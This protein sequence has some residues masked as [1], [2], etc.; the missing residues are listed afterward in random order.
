MT[1]PGRRI[2]QGLGGTPPP[3]HVGETSAGSN[4]KE[5]LRV[6]G[7]REDLEVLRAFIQQ[8]S[9]PIAVDMSKE[10]RRLMKGIVL[11]I[12][13][14]YRAKAKLDRTRDDEIPV[15]LRNI[16][17]YVEKIWDLISEMGFEVT[18]YLNQTYSDGLPMEVLEFLPV[19]GIS[20]SRI[21]ECVRPSIRL[22]TEGNEA[23]S[24]LLQKAEVFVEIPKEY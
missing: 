5:S 21:S 19:D 24:L 6:E 4:L 13:E 15:S 22:R 18:D 9:A 3:L 20:S 14:A 11:I 12:N 2:P 7:S 8:G 10:Q 23:L 17:R 16:P 1:K